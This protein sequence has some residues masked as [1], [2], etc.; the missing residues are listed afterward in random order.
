M[1]QLY[2]PKDYTNQSKKFFSEQ[3]SSEDCRSS[4]E[5]F[6]PHF[7]IL[8]P[9]FAEDKQNLLLSSLNWLG[10]FFCCVGGLSVGDSHCCH[11]PASNLH[12]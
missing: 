1:S 5:Q 2:W 10:K 11:Y 9:S 6:Y 3:R 4:S 8:I 7:T 12:H